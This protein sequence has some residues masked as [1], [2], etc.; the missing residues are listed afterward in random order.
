MLLLSE[1]AL[2]TVVL[3]PVG[4]VVDTL[5]VGLIVSPLSLILVPVGV[6]EDSPTESVVVLPLA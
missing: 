5:S 3:S 6:V 4:V 1:S 2:L